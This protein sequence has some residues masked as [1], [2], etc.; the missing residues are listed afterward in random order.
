MAYLSKEQYGLA[1]AD[2]NK[3][4]QLSQDAN[5]VNAARKLIEQ[6]SE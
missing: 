6:L 3:V 5:E 1:I 2:C 4:I